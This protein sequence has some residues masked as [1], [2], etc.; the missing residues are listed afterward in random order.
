M[1]HI[2]D[3]IV[4]QVTAILRDTINPPS[5][6]ARIRFLIASPFASRLTASSGLGYV[7]YLK[8]WSGVELQ[9]HIFLSLA[10][11]GI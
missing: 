9:F 7:H 8:E 2:L 5:L 4:T 10:L 11:Y 6:P 1:S 3:A